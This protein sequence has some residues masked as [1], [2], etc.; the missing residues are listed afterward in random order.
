L[1]YKSE[2]MKKLFFLLFI[3][4][5][6]QFVFS[7]NVG[8]GTATPAYPLTV[9][10]AGN[11]IVHKGGAVE[12]GT[13]V[14]ALGGMLQTFTNH[15]L[16]FG[17]GSNVTKMILTTTGEL[18]IGTS[19]PYAR[20]HATANYSSLLQLEN[21]STLAVGVTVKQLYK[22]GTYYTGA[23]GTTGEGSG[24]A[25]LSFFTGANINS[26]SL[27]ERM[28][29]LSNGNVAIGTTT[30]LAKFHVAGKTMLEQQ[31]WD[32]A[33][34]EISGAIKVSGPAPAAFSVLIPQSNNEWG[35]PEV[36]TYIDNPACN[37]KPNALLFVTP[38]GDF[39]QTLLVKYEAGVGKWKLMPD[40]LEN[41][42]MLPGARYNILV[43]DK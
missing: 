27:A 9:N 30:P 43:I 40:Q 5:T 18:A 16:R 11:G 6:C 20:M 14:S 34:V 24:T 42:Y 3:S 10:A 26:A 4:F 22:T 19:L 2:T 37:G 41:G 17:A 21:T 28:C 31:S 32:F 36:S 25:R 1:C 15:H 38:A 29:I 39:A 35:I 7:Q 8:I 23:I 33:A 12:I 13:S